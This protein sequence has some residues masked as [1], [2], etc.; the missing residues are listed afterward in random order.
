V[1]ADARRASLL[2][3]LLQ[4]PNRVGL[5]SPPG[6]NP[7]GP[8]RISR[9]KRPSARQHPDRRAAGGGRLAARCTGEQQ[10]APEHCSEPEDESD[11]KHRQCNAGA[12][13]DERKQS[14]SDNE[15]ERADF[16]LGLRDVRHRDFRSDDGA[17]G[18]KP[19]PPA[20]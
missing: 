5:I 8:G 13:R 14:R 10:L 15:R 2:A 18:L 20:V 6:G 1:I 12:Q 9:I 19:T 7:V 16:P 17:S 11:Q 4:V 3:R